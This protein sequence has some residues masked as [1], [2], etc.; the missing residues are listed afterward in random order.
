MDLKINWGG[1]E[2]QT[3]K[4]AKWDQNELND[5]NQGKTASRLLFW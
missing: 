4:K 2:N 5:S 1:G 3:L